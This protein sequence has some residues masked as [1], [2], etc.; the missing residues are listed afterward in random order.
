VTKKITVALFCIQ[1]AFSVSAQKDSTRHPVYRVKPV[2]ELPAAAAGAVLSIIGFGQLR[3]KASLSAADVLKLD[4]AT[5][6]SFDRPAAFID[7]SEFE[8]AD[9]RSSLFLNIT[10]CSP[11][12][13]GLDKEIRRDWVD[14]LSLYLMTHAADNAVYF[15]AAFS[16][17]RP[18][19][20]TYNSLVPLSEKTG[21]GKTNSFFSAH[22]SFS[23]TA[24]FFMAKVYTDYHHIRGWNRIL[25]YTI[26]AV[27]PALVGYYRMRAGKH[28]KTDVMF[29]FLAGAASG[30]IVPELHRYKN[31]KHAV[32]FTPYYD[33]GA[34]GMAMTVKL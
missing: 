2:V 23:S 5:I 16:V 20:L 6:N 13:L 1:I 22:T 3:T 28:F 33:E 18:R 4:P 21:T 31:N 11:L 12:L 10:L 19:P 14:L 34:G 15:G 32:T 24:T 17:R 8:E 7:P 25:A 29:G 26:A 9:K 27:P 30:I